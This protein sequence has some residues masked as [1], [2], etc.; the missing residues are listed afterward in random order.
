MGR[1][2]KYN[3]KLSEYVGF[4]LTE[5]QKDELEDMANEK[6]VSLGDLIRDIVL[7]EIDP[8]KKVKQYD[9]ELEKLEEKMDNIRERKK[10]AERIREEKNKALL[11]HKDEIFKGLFEY[12]EKMDFNLNRYN[13]DYL[14]NDFFDGNAPEN[15]DFSEIKVNKRE[16]LNDLITDYRNL[17]GTTKEEKREKVNEMVDKL[18]EYDILEKKGF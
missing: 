12:F 2:R 10:K 14:T 1:K 15:L 7:D 17:G 16:E 13:I 18:I 11:S 9:K 5:E 3:K 6:G 4:K 8:S